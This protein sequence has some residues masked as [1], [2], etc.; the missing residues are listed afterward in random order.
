ME[1]DRNELLSK[2]E[3]TLRGAPDE[4]KFAWLAPY[5]EAF[6]D[7]SEEVPPLDDLIDAWVENQGQIVEGA[8]KEFQEMQ[9]QLEADVWRFRVTKEELFIEIDLLRKEN[10]KQSYSVAFLR[11][12]GAD[13]EKYLEISRERVGLWK[14][15]AY[16][17]IALHRVSQEPEGSSE[18]PM[19]AETVKLDKELMA[20]RKAIFEEYVGIAG[21][22]DE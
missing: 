3:R 17:L 2:L 8:E 7:D 10:E 5:F 6:V 19:R 9:A 20:A 22:C 21:D 18:I 16:F 4:V 15:E 12:R 13:L 11:D 14:R 1:K